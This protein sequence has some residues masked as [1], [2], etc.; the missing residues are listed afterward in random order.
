MGTKVKDWNDVDNIDR[1]TGALELYEDA[2]ERQ[3]AAALDADESRIRLIDAIIDANLQ[4]TLR[5]DTCALRAALKHSRCN[6]K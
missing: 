1:A 6:C 2:K 5:V 3:R 4:H